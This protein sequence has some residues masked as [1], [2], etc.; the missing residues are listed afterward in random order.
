VLE[1]RL[2][3]HHVGGRSG[4]RSF[5]VLPAFEKDIINVM[6]D[7]DASC[8]AQ[9]IDTW[10]AQPSKTIVLPYCLSAREGVCE[11]HINYEPY[12]SSIYSL[13]PRYAQFY[14][15]PSGQNLRQGVDYV[16]GD[17]FRTMREVH[18]PM[19]TLDAVI[20][21]R[22]EVP[23]PAFLSIDTQGSELA[24]LDGSS[25]LLDTT[26][27]GVQTE[28]GL[29]PLYEGQ[30]LFGDICQFLAKH[31]FDLVDIDVF[32]KLYPIRGKHGFRGEGYAAHGEALFL[33]RP[34][35]VQDSL[36]L[37]KLA[38]IA[39]TFGQFECAQQCFESPAFETMAPSSST[40]AD[41]QPR[42]LDFVSRLARAVAL[43]PKRSVPLFSDVYSFAQSEA[44]CQMQTS[45]WALR[46]KY[47]KAIAPLGFAVRV[48]RL[49]RQ[50]L[51]ALRI[52]AV[53][54]GHRWFR[55]SG[56]AVEALFLEFGMTD[57]YLLAMRNRILD[58]EVR[59]RPT[60][61]SLNRVL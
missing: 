30:P 53:I 48:L 42:Y 34:E 18:L 41:E 57:Q 36:Q 26:I 10:E 7:A 11:F 55:H 28:I 61:T 4:S 16:L 12:S 2:V 29:H 32:A 46:K 25:R 58:S 56:S 38:F 60:G 37:T 1:N 47:L 43:L 23:G 40:A 52:S 14:M 59:L 22:N 35:T 20:L 44:R 19:T 6:Y 45:R 17:V 39:A 13:N 8:L 21:D 27:L 50:R 51:N 49:L 5:P 15:P 33:K 3:I 9:I 31:K 24:I 54:G